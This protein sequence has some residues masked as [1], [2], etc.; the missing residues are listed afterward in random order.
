MSKS[1]RKKSGK[2]GLRNFSIVYILVT[3]FIPFIPIIIWS[4]AFRW[5]YPNVVP[6]WG[7]RAWKYA[8]S[9]KSIISSLLLSINV[10]LTVTLISLCV[11]MPAAKVLGTKDF[12]GKKVVETI[13]TLPA[14]VP[15]LV[16]IMGLQVIFIKINLIN[17]FWG[18]VIV[19]LIPT[20]PYMIMYLQSTFE[21]YPVSY[22]DQAKVLGAS[23]MVTFFQITIPIIYPGIIV[24]SL[25]AFLVSWS[26]YL[27]TI[28]IGGPNVRTLP[29]QLFAFI[30]SGDNAISAVVSIIFV[31]PA[32]LML[33]ITSRYLSGNGEKKSGGNEV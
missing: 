15:V 4:F 3:V 13:V 17:T 29:T 26:Q 12:K 20:I 30:G 8:L 22:E 23:T 7:L 27:L 18:V 9:Q 6:E 28:M 16:V 25:Y 19:Q 24:A 11:G 1:K 10:S 33:L 5:N 32:I 21:D 31:F 14:I 2:N